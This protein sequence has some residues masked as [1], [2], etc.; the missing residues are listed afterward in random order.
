[1]VALR[2][3]VRFSTHWATSEHNYYYQPAP[4]SLVEVHRGSEDLYRRPYAIKTQRKARNAPEGWH[5]VPK[6]CLYG[7]REL[8]T[9]R[10]WSRTNQTIVF[11]EMPLSYCHTHDSA[12][13]RP[14]SISLIY[15]RR[16]EYLT[17]HVVQVTECLDMSRR[18]RLP[19]RATISE[20]TERSHCCRVLHSHC[21]LVG[22][23]WD[24]VFLLVDILL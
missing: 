22:T 18:C 13:G 6:L 2:E 23:H 7:I 12:D 8:A 21:S 10:T 4:L 15:S 9:P 20:I 17:L 1:M 11:I 24:T 14:W 16:E 3:K 19:A 5:F